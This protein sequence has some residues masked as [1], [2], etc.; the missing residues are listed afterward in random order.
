MFSISRSRSPLR[1]SSSSRIWVTIWTPSLKTSANTRSCLS[2]SPPSS[3][4]MQALSSSHRSSRWIL[5]CPRNFYTLL[6]GYFP[7]WAQCGW[8]LRSGTH[9]RNDLITHSPRNRMTSVSLA[10]VQSSKL[11]RSGM[12]W[13]VQGQ[14]IW[15]AWCTSWI[16]D[17]YRL[18]PLRM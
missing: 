7:Q 17:V 4:A 11:G 15:G 12:S 13:G 6:W 10:V 5:T 18:S 14:E 3:L 1:S 16:L 2:C 8:K 9:I